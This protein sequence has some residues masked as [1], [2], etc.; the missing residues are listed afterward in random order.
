MAQV[1]IYAVFIGTKTLKLRHL[2]ANRFMYWFT[3]KE[4]NTHHNIISTNYAISKILGDFMI[5]YD[6]ISFMK[7]YLYLG[8]IFYVL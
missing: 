8:L 4:V 3:S 1:S 6:L 2:Y 7:V 5:L